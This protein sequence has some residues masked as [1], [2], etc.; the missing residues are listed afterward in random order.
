MQSLCSHR[1]YIPV[2]TFPI[3]NFK[4]RLLQ[5]KSKLYKGNKQ[6]GLTERSGEMDFSWGNRRKP[7]CRGD[8]EVT[9]EG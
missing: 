2:E 9:T 8:N 1:A 7:L 3:H 6:V 4:M 5:V